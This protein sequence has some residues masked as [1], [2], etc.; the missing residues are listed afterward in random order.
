MCLF[1]AKLYLK[2]RKICKVS[3]KELAIDVLGFFPVQMSYGVITSGLINL[4]VHSSL[5]D[6][7]V[8]HGENTNFGILYYEV[9]SSPFILWKSYLDIL[10][11]IVLNHCD[12][13]IIPV[14]LSELGTDECRKVTVCTPMS[15]VLDWKKNKIKEFV[16]TSSISLWKKLAE[17]SSHTVDSCYMFEVFSTYQQ[18]IDYKNQY[19]SVEWEDE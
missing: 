12:N 9:I 3:E 17:H 1:Y 6:K 8:L 5:C 18:G 2:N 7:Q 15:Y 14:L 16:F 4:F 11:K 19:L 10:A 13:Y